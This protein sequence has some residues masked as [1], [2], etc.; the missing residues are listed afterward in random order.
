MKRDRSRWDI[1]RVRF[2]LNSPPAPQRD[3]KEIGELLPDILSSLERPKDE[4]ITVLVGAWPKLT[5]PQVSAHSRPGYFQDRT[6][7]VFV[8][9][10]G[11]IAEL[12]RIKRPLLQKLQQHY[13]EMK[14][15]Q[16]RFV[17]EAKFEK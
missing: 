9:H 12:Q 8:N 16:L 2:H 4:N 11:W 5:G 15:R 13:R 6:L 3:L 14:I 10:P 17:Y 1:D 7:Y